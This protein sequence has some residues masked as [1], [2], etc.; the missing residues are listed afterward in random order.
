MNEELSR[1]I[2]YKSLPSTGLYSTTKIAAVVGSTLPISWNS[3]LPFKFS[4]SEPL[5]FSARTFFVLKKLSSDGLRR[6]SWGLIT[7]TS[8][9]YSALNK[10]LYDVSVPLVV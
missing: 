7:S 3:V 1:E 4:G 9:P 6:K 8:L 2:S 5:I 10:S